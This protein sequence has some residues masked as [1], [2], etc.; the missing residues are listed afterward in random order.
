MEMAITIKKTVTIFTHGH[1]YSMLKLN[2]NSQL[3]NI[4][5]NL[6]YKDQEI[7]LW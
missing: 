6:N 5:L 7:F 3:I 4:Q 2:S 1:I